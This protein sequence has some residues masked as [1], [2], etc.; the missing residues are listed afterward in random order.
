MPM[1]AAAGTVHL[2]GTHG[3]GD[4]ELMLL[5]AF[6]LS[7]AILDAACRVRAAT[8]PS[9]T[10]WLIGGSLVVGLGIFAFHFIALLSVELPLPITADP[11]MFGVS[12]VTAVIAAAGALH[13]V[14]RGV[15]GVP[16]FAISAGLKGFA[17]VA[18]HYTSIAA[19]HVP[20]TID[21]RP[22][23]VIGSALIAVGVSA[24]ALALA[25]RLRSESP[26]RAAVERAVGALVMAGG[27]V[28]F[29]HASASGGLFVPDDL[30]VK[31]ATEGHHLHALAQAWMAPWLAGAG[32]VTV[33]TLAVISTFSRRSHWRQQTRPAT[34]RLTGLANRELLRERVANAFH[35]GLPCAVVAVRVKRF[36]QIRQRLGRPDAEQMLVRVGQRLR[37]AARPDDLVS[38]VGGAEFGVLVLDARREVVHDV[39]ERITARLASPVKIGALT[40][41]APTAV[42]AATAL[43]TDTP[44]ELLRRAQIDAR[45]TATRPALA[46]VEAAAP[47]QTADVVQLRAA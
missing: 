28:A 41:V 19:L 20:A 44:A 3:G 39:A 14:N 40:V 17:L 25:E 26:G 38:Y 30:W 4:M 43:P 46:L 31:H 27:L 29:H 13:H 16:P 37:S 45:R 22:S 21:Y 12:A 18:T 8:G 33:A 34:D 7:Y 1:F 36:E 2:H 23:I 15:A 24:L 5:V 42:G 47:E 10:L 9:R 32:V 11:V 6:V 35:E